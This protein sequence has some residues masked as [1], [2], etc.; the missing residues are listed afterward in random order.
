MLFNEILSAKLL[1]FCKRFSWKIHYKRTT[2]VL[3]PELQNLG[4][5][6]SGKETQ[7]CASDSTYLNYQLRGGKRILSH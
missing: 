4:S 1:I 7:F 3:L 6:M 2:E 5:K